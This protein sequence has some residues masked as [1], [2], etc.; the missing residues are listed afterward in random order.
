MEESFALA[1]GK[2]FSCSDGSENDACQGKTHHPR[3]QFYPAAVLSDTS[4]LCETLKKLLE[5]LNV[6][7]S[8]Q[9]RQHLLRADIFGAVWLLETCLCASNTW[10]EMCVGNSFL[11]E[12]SQVTLPPCF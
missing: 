1:V 2:I 11:Q 4:G 3:S 5:A 8:V 6:W 9:V 12:V 10:V 7:L